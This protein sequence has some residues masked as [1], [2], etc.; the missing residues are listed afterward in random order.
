[1]S[2]CKKRGVKIVYGLLSVFLATE[3]CFDE[4]VACEKYADEGKCF[5]EGYYHYGHYCKK[6]CG[7]CGKCIIISHH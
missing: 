3:A 7:L 6:S 2:Y 4:S 5:N 1:M